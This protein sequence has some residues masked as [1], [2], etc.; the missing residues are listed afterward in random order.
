VT[1][2][3][4]ANMLSEMRKRECLRNRGV[5]A[6]ERE[7]DLSAAFLSAITVSELATWVALVKRRDAAQGPLIEQWFHGR[8]LELF[9]PR[10]LPVD[11]GIAVRAGLLHVPDPRDYRDAFI[12]ATALVHG[13]TIVTRNVA[14][15][16]PTGAKVFNPFT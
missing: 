8:V 16:A 7:T 4:D 5:K 11:T 3:L 1:L 14:G 2:L 12:A 6:W 13:L 10:I 9:G 15:F